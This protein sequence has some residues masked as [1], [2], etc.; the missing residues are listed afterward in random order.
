V[1]R[2]NSGGSLQDTYDLGD[3][4]NGPPR[5]TLGLDD[6]SFWAFT[7]PVLSSATFSHV[8]LSDGVVLSTYTMTTVE[9]GGRNN[10]VVFG[11]SRS[12]PILVLPKEIALIQLPVFVTGT[13]TSIPIRR[14]RSTPVVNSD[15]NWLFFKSL[16]VDL[17]V[18]LG[19]VT[20]QG[21]DPQVELFW[22]NDGGMTWQG[23][24]VMSA[25]ALGA[26]QQRVRWL[27]LGRARNRVFRIVVSDPIAW[28]ILQAFVDLE[29]GLS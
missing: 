24:R 8:R 10:D 28:R 23:P 11:P 14:L 4:V 13:P 18:G 25:G 9:P 22:S 1:K 29:P 27:Q 5:L 16:E 21:V 2:Y 7:I 17:Q 20:G 19:A 15:G 12:C 6:A 26:Y 3:S